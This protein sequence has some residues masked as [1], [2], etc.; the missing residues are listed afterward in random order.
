MKREKHRDDRDY[1]KSQL[2][3]NFHGKNLHRD[4][5][6]HFFRWSFAKRFSSPTTNVL[7]IGCGQ[8]TPLMNIL[9][10]SAV[11]RLCGVYVGCDL[12]KLRTTNHNRC[13]LF[14]EFNFVEQ[15]DELLDMFPAKFGMITHFEVFEHM[16][17]IHGLVLLENCRKL[18][19]DDGVMIMSTPCYDGKRHAANHI[20]EY[21][22]EELHAA[23]IECGFTVEKRFG[24]FMDVRHIGKDHGRFDSDPPIDLQE[25]IAR[26]FDS[27]ANY[28]SNDALSCFFAPLYP[29]RSRN[30]VWICRGSSRTR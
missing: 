16:L 3:E 11:N 15:G 19:A 18:L 25:P 7:D 12:N 24:T 8:D 27:L 10:K 4:Y 13:H 5:S 2:R 29:D 6:A 22:N 17:P 9:T 30:N 1:D 21:T 23:L 14:G 28:Y 20:H 26:L